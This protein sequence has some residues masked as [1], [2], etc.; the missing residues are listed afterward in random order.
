M[1]ITMF[2]FQLQ[3]KVLYSAHVEVLSK[4]RNQFMVKSALYCTICQ[5]QDL[6]D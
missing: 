2:L 6:Q 5:H 4:I 1:Q 3:I